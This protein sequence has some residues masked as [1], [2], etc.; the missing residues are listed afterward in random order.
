MKEISASSAKKAKELLKKMSMEEKLYQLSGCMIF[1]ID[2][3]YD[4]C[5]NPLY[6]NYRSAGHFMHWKRKE[7]A[8]PS[9]VARGSIR[10]YVPVS[11]L[12]LM[13]F[14]RLFMRRLCMEHSGEWRQC[15]RS[16]LAWHPALMMN[17][18]RK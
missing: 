12:S 4:Q 15:F 7:P 9:E 11:R 2:E 5:R 17:W 6:G 3:T 10:I 1:D 13:G 16:R 14:P 18:Y 8:A